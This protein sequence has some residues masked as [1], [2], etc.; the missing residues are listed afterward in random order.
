MRTLA[1][2]DVHL[3]EP[4]KRERGQGLRIP[5]KYVNGPVSIVQWTKADP[6]PA[7]GPCVG[8]D[9]ETE[10]I[11]ETNSA[12][13]LVVLGVF[14]PKS[15][16]CYISYWEDAG[17]FIQ[18]L[19]KREIQQRYFNLGFDE[20]VLS[21]VDEDKSLLQAIE[22]GRVRDMQIRIQLHDIATIGYIP[23][24]HWS[25]E[26]CS[27]L[28]LD[29]QL[30]KGEKD[31]PDSHRLT[32]RRG[33]AITEE[34][35]IYLCMDCAT[36]YA[37]GEAISEQPTEV[38]HTKGMC[39]LAHISHNGFPVDMRVFEAFEEKLK[40][41]R[42][43]YRLKLLDFGFPDPYAKSKD[44]NGYYKQFAVDQVNLFMAKAKVKAE[45]PLNLCKA[46]VRMALVYMY[47][48]A[49]ERDQ[50]KDLE[51]SVSYWLTQEKP[52]NLRKS[53][54]DLYTQMVNEYDLL[55]F[56]DA[57]KD[58]VINALI[59]HIMEDLNAQIDEQAPWYDLNRAI[60]HASEIIDANPHWLSDEKPIGPR[61]Y[62]QE[63]YRLLEDRH[64]GLTLPRTPNT[65]EMKLTL[66]D[67]WMLDDF[68]I[69]DPFVSTYTGYTH[70]T[71][72][73]STYLNREFI[74]ADGRIHARFTN[75]MKTGRTSCTRP[76][77]Q[78]LPSRDKQYPLKNMFCPP[79]GAI[80]C[81]TDFS[82]IELCAFAQTCYSRFGAS[83]MRD[84]INAGIDPHRW[85]SGVMNK[86]IDANL[87]KKDDPEWVKWLNDFLKEKITSEARQ[88]AK[89][90]N[91]GLPGRM[92]PDRFYIHLRSNGLKATPED[93]K[94]MCEAWTN[95]F[96]EMQKHKFPQKAK[97]TKKSAAVY[98]MERKDSED[99]E[100]ENVGGDFMA[101]LPCGQVRNHCSINAACNTQFQ[102]TT[103]IGAKMAGWNL[104][105]NGYGDRLLNFVH[106]EYL[107]WLW[108]NEL[109]THIP[110]IESLMIAGMKTVIP[111]VKVGVESSCML[112]WDKKAT[113]FSK[114]SFDDNGLPILEEPPFV[115]ELL[116]QTT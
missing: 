70:A 111:D 12:P 97:S 73:L 35:A 27:R 71:K 50:K 8:V 88:L 91:F 49:Y 63:H 5:R 26:D 29:T 109:Q 25:L 57:R 38:Q 82:F 67:M 98:G 92:G 41:Q 13:P 15:K 113:E 9:T 84:V 56:M 81:A 58:I 2:A 42:D 28:Y 99:E 33:T 20:H 93:A 77:L 40:A 105:Y 96:T 32:F 52:K 104:L 51:E 61:T 23:Y 86:V 47:N 16:I 17:V 110:I 43:A 11:T 54:Q 100:E 22:N 14:D 72:Y 24:N 115:K 21:D 45:T 85:F 95:T 60:E 64:P 4:E 112:H 37:L 89:A 39:V 103:A 3:N 78:N 65:G 59:G 74:R 75:L 80:L 44:E 76:N 7:L 1:T 6:F 19:S 31:D 34:Q 83:V 69:K 87:D 66:Q 68:D 62:L 36:T 108:P 90:A 107:Y 102:A 94:N 101:K 18:E 30:D 10:L 48:F 46:N 53:E 55:K 114:L 116:S 106:D 79:K